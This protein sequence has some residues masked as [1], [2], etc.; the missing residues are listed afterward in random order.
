MCFS[1]CHRCA[2]FHLCS[3]PCIGVAVRE[4]TFSG[5]D[6]TLVVGHIQTQALSYLWRQN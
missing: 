6:G 1:K 4:G 3:G 2:L 5:V